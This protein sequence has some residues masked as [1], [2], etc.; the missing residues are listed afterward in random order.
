MLFYR[1]TTGD[2]F[3]VRRLPQNILIAHPCLMSGHEFRVMSVGLLGDGVR[4]VV[5][6]AFLSEWLA[7]E[8]VSSALAAVSKW[9]SP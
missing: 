4:G 9:A 1:F 2:D 7:R 8:I 5:F 6:M 3:L